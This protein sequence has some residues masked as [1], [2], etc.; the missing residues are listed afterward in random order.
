MASYPLPPGK[1]LFERHLQDH[2]ATGWDGVTLTGFSRAV[3]APGT[4]LVAD[5]ITTA[6]SIDYTFPAL[7]EAQ[8]VYVYFCWEATQTY[9]GAETPVDTPLGN[10]WTT[11]GPLW[12]YSGETGNTTTRVGFKYVTTTAAPTTPLS[13]DGFRPGSFYL[14]RGRFLLRFARGSASLLGINIKRAYVAVVE[15]PRPRLNFPNVEAYL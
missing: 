11:E 2:G 14:R 1:I 3:A 4:A 8:E 9:S 7:R 5:G 12:T 10:R 6:V 13:S 15:A